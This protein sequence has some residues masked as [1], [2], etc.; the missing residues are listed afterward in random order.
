LSENAKTVPTPPPPPLRGEILKL[1]DIDTGFSEKNPK[2]NRPYVV[3]GA[4]GMLVRVVP[5]STDLSK[6]VLIPDGGVEGLE[7]GCFV[8][9]AAN[10]PLSLAITAENVGHLPEPYLSEVIDQAYPG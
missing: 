9:Y 6:G 5:Q 10:V 3:V 1:D 2:R 7:E 4:A 8:P